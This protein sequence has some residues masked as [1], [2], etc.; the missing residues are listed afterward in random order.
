M[1]KSMAASAVAAVPADR[2]VVKPGR[3]RSVDLLRGMTIASM[4]LV[5]DPGDWGHVFPQLDHAP[6]NGWTLTDAVFPMF[7]FLVGVSIVLSMA[8]REAKGD[9]KGTQANHILLRFVK[10]VVLA[11]ALNFFPR[12]HWTMRIYGVLMRIALCY[13]TAALILLASRKAKV[14]ASVAAVLLVGYW[15]LLRWVRI[16]GAGHP[17]VDFPFLDPMWNMTAW[18]DRGVSAW[19]L[20]WLHTGTLYQ[21]TR[22]PE[23]LL[24]TLPAV[25]SVLLGALAGI[26]LRLPQWRTQR[27][28]TFNA[29]MAWG[30]L[31]FVGGSLWGRWFPV[32]KNLWTSSYVLVMAGIAVCL[33]AL[34]H[35]L[36]DERQAPWPRWLQVVTW[37]WFV[38][39]SNA[40]AAF[41]ISIVL[42]KTLIYLKGTA[43]DGARRT[44]WSLA[45]KDG[46]ARHGSNEWTS[47]AFALCFV[48]VCFVPVWMLWRKKI[49]LKL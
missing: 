48:V 4:I 20:K 7:L 9:G 47:L 23:G 22:D 29:M 36:V 1:M 14:I 46:F 38:F 41:T 35:V 18:V 6:W 8:V 44:L 16:P 12:M 32:N 19:T 15:V 42:V 24:S 25:A 13:L 28:A 39:G 49:F 3:V 11:W 45:Y 21:K 27:N 2:T 34:F 31:M 10:L 17:G 40:I 43:A 33:L 26:Y 30:G 37:P 5:N